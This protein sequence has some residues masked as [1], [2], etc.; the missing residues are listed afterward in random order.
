MWKMPQINEILHLGDTTYT[1]TFHMKT[2]FHKNLWSSVFGVALTEVLFVNLG[3]ILADLQGH[4][5]T[6]WLTNLHD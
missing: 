5:Q 6:R 3:L 2:T 4:L 1:H